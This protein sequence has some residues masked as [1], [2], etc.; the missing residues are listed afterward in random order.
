MSQTSDKPKYVVP[1]GM[2]RAM[3]AAL[4]EHQRSH[5]FVGCV[6][7]SACSLTHGLEAALRWLAESNPLP[8]ESQY[9]S[10]YR[11]Y[12]ADCITSGEQGLM[13]YWRF[14]GMLR[15]W[16]QQMFLQ[17]EPAVPEEIKDLIN[18]CFAGTSIA[19]EDVQKFVREAYRRGRVSQ[20][21]DSASERD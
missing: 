4:E 18:C 21:Q 12:Y 3:Y 19:A 10:L 9:L 15:E 1:E 11:K 14:V 8:L 20:A 2:T 5:S 6:I 7:S 13:V 17:P 16:Q